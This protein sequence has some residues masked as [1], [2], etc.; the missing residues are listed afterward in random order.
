MADHSCLRTRANVSGHSGCQ[1]SERRKTE[2]WRVKLSFRDISVADNELNSQQCVVFFKVFLEIAFLTSVFSS[3]M[4]CLIKTVKTEGYFGM[5]RGE[6]EATPTARS[7]L[8]NDLTLS[9]SL[10]WVH[11]LIT[12]LCGCRRSCESHPGDAWKGHQTCCK[13]LFPPSAEQRWVSVVVWSATHCCA[14]AHL[15]F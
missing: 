4:D 7:H 13:W 11:C 1:P 14:V 6:T 3:R 2:Q 10:C 12:C 8:L 9:W 5:Y 15:G